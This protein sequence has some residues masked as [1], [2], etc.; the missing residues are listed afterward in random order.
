MSGT[1]QSVDFDTHFWQPIELWQPLI[2]KE[3]STAVVD[4]FDA[5]SPMRTGRFDQK[6]KDAVA[7]RLTDPAADDPH[8]R[9]RWMDENGIGATVIYPSHGQYSFAAD[10]EVAA[11]GCRAINRW[12]SQFAAADRARL[13][14][15][16]MLPVM[17]PD[18]AL[19]EF[20][21]ATDEL[22]LEVVFIC[23]TPDRERRWSDEA[24]DP[25][26]AAMQDAGTV[27]TFHEFTRIDADR[28]DL[29]TVARASYKD[30]YPLGYVCGHTV[31]LQVAVTDLIAG[32]MLDRFPELPVG[33]AEGHVAW[34]P[35]WLALLDDLW[36]N[37]TT[38]FG[39]QAAAGGPLPSEQFQR[40][41]FVVVFPNDAWIEQTA[42][43]VSPDVMAVCSDFP[44]PNGAGRMPLETVLRSSSPGLTEGEV[45]Q[46]LYGNAA[47]I[48]RLPAAV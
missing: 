46:V 40:Q 6:I 26:W 14:P 43:M 44:H 42:H 22:G 39:Q 7:E 5:T 16:M 41:C 47:R 1:R 48:L 4:F 27:L 31:E 18:L 25:L 24:F 8:E 32:G 15:T 37:L 12:A 38:R 30:L 36:P 19:E 10:P 3:H 20:R 35:G 33:L 29:Q 21:Y 9:I 28:T 23:P 17:F 13:K 2:D 45:E 11:A 34:L